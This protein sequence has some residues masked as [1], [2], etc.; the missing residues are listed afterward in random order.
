MIST[1]PLN[2]ENE[3]YFMSPYI[4]FSDFGRGDM[5]KWGIVI[6]YSSGWVFGVQAGF[7]L[8]QL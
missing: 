2:Q 1:P 6:N 5:L 8:W 7:S 3:K 4:S